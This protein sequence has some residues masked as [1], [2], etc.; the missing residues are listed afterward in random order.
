MEKLKLMNMCEKDVDVEIR[1]KKWQC[2]V[3]VDKQC[4]RMVVRLG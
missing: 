3:A 1:E 2:E 4:I